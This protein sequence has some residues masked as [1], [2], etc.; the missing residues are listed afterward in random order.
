MPDKITTTAK[1]KQLWENKNNNQQKIM[2]YTNFVNA[3]T[4]EP[5][6]HFKWLTAKR[7]RANSGGVLMLDIVKK[8]SRLV[9][10]WRSS[11][12]FNLTSL[13]VKFKKAKF[14]Q[15]END[16]SKAVIAQNMLKL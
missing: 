3:N 5:K 4:F 12:T 1:Q 16:F 10:Q 8:S 9:S 6:G 2:N 13:K 7:S 15:T 14:E 11:V